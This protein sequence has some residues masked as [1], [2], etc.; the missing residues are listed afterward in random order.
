MAKEPLFTLDP[1]PKFTVTVNIPRPGENEDGKLVM[2]F[3]HHPIDEFTNTMAE[4]E[5]TLAQIDEND[6]QGFDIMANAVMHI[7]DDWGFSKAPH[8]EPFTIEN[9]R[10][11]LVNYPR[12]FGAI[13][14][15]YYLELMG[16]REKN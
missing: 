10:R 15:T 9:V 3:K 8:N 2:E 13:H 16:L 5:H 7:A 4:T 1:N 14:G 6:P 11:L 12:A